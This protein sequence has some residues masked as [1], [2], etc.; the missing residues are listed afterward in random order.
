MG[1]YPVLAVNA[2]IVLINVVFLKRM[3]PGRSEAFDLLALDRIE[4]RY[5]Q[6]FLEFHGRDIR[7]FFP[8]IDFA[9]F[10]GSRVVLILRDVLPVG[11]VIC[12]RTDDRTLT[13]KLDYVIP[14]YRDFRC[15]EYFYKSWD[16]IIDC[17]GVCRF[18]TTGRVDAHRAYLKRMGFAPD[19]DLGP[20]RYSRPA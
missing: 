17:G 9:S 13:I 2:Y 15:A 10:A 6:R 3:Q 11:V 4:N 14:A 16:D 18:V 8:G 12:E 19:P 5:L 20:D 7:R 1:A